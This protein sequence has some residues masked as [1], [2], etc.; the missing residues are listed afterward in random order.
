MY[1]PH[2]R[3][4]ELFLVLHRPGF[5]VFGDKG[6]GEDIDRKNERFRKRTKVFHVMLATSFW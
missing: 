6:R 1:I 3:L 2:S 5:D 4:S